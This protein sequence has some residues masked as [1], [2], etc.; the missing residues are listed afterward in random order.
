VRHGLKEVGEC[1]SVVSGRALFG[2]C[3]GR[4]GYTHAAIKSS[5]SIFLVCTGARQNPA[6]C[7]RNDGN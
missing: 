4:S 7:K 6:E 3:G 5:F 1:L 2:C